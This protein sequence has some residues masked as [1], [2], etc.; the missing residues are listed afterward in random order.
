E[1][2]LRVPLV[3]GPR[4]IP[5]P[6][7]QVVSVADGA[8]LVNISDPVPDRDKISPPVLDPRKFG[9]INPVTL[10]VEL[11]SGVSLAAIESP[12]HAVDI[13][14]PDDKTATVEVKGAVP[15]DRDFVLNWHLKANAAPQATLYRETIGAD[16][17]Y[18]AMIV[19]PVGTQAPKRQSRE[20]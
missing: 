6:E 2:S 5:A 8:S 13:Q 1:L 4:Y 18:L 7:A 17:Y 9:K 20:A 11:K 3:V 15:A 12:Y 19:P 14:R 10:K 16:N